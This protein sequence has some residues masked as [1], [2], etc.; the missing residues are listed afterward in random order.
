MG[1]SNQR[2]T[3]LA[4]KGC[5]IAVLA[6]TALAVPMSPGFAQDTGRQITTTIDE[7]MVTAQRRRENAQD[8]AV[9]VTT[10][11]AAALAKTFARDLQDVETQSPNLIIDPIF[12]PNTA[13]ISIRGVQLNDG[14]KSFDPAVAVYLDGVYLA[15]T[16]G[17]LLNMWDAEAVEI[18]RGPQGTL[19]GR[20][21]IG[22]LVHLKRAK[23]TGEL[24]GKA[25]ITYGRFDL[26]DARAS[27]NLP[28]LGDSL[29]TKFSV[30]RS[31]GGGYFWNETRNEREG[32]ANLT[33]LTGMA[34]WTPT[35]NFTL[36]VVY[37]YV[38]D[39]TES[40]PHTA[41]TQPGTLFCSPDF[42]LAGCGQPPSNVSYHRNTRTAVAQPARLETHAVTLNGKL[43]LNENHSLEGVFGWRDTDEE[44]VTK[45]DGVEAFLF[46]TERPQTLEQW[47]GEL[48]WHGNWME[49][50]VKSV[51][52]VYYFDSSYDLAQRSLSPIFFGGLGPL[53]EQ[54]TSFGQST[55][56][57]AVFGQLD[58]SI[59]R[60]LTVTVGGRWLDEKKRACGDDYIYDGATDTILLG[61]A[62]GDCS[63][64]VVPLEEQYIDPATGLL[65]DTQGSKSWSKFTPR[66][67]LT[68]NFGNGIIFGTYSEGFRSGGFNGRA[69]SADTLGPYDP[70]KVSSFEFGFKSDWANNRVQ[71]NAV[72]FLT[73]Y[74][75]KQE[76]V[77]FPVVGGSTV[78]VVQNAASAKINGFEIEARAIPAPGLT[79][80][81]ALG[82]LDAKYDS[83]TVLGLDGSTVDKSDFKLRRAPKLTLNFNAMYEHELNNGHFL[84]FTGSVSHRSP[85]YVNANTIT[86]SPE[87]LGRNKATTTV[88]LSANYETSNWRFS[89]FGKNITG[90]DFFLHVL[91]VGTQYVAAGPNDQSPVPV[92][93]LFT[94]GTINSPATWGLEIQVKF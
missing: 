52:G 35:D 82:Y 13:A 50:R 62:F 59:T 73:K 5:S 46:M 44:A 88:D 64:P 48:R 87:P 29:A 90:E 78:T 15:T 58:F 60:D 94:Y 56:S 84:V 45:W 54:R 23:P 65:V 72:G 57:F 12:G 81:A 70:E 69:T 39:K 40:L 10:L 11:D 22:G 41:L 17:A 80:G 16:T 67:G 18:L 27:L 53:V 92:P 4:L 19:F 21:T 20:N 2:S 47:S 83:W 86:P 77:V 66:V 28:K 38:L 43:D 49:D 36:D 31:T 34:T 75:N 63:N 79:L 74:D 32:E 93:G 7:I 42:T 26:L 14:E 6:A 85:Y 76:D 33:S 24:G 25:Q 55:K 89:V 91:D 61:R 68:Y 1:T 8:I 51:L 3:R 37:E 71:F 9:Q 30:I